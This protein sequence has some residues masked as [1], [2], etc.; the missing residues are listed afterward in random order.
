METPSPEERWKEFYTAEIALLHSLTGT[1]TG[2]PVALP[3][4]TAVADAPPKP[5]ASKK[6]SKGTADDD[7]DENDSAEDD[8][9]PAPPSAAGSSQLAGKRKAKA[10]PLAVTP[11]E[12]AVPS[13]SAWC[14]L[15]TELV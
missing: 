15:C 12:S 13:E 2:D 4:V 1:K 6:K 7:E 8:A 9:E 10:A 3:A 11:D 14:N 5:K